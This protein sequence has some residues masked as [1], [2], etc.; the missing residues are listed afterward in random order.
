MVNAI[1]IEKMKHI[2]QRIAQLFLIAVFIIGPVSC[3]K[4]SNTLIPWV[5]VSIQISLANHIDLNAPGGYIY[6]PDQG[7]AGIIVYCVD[8]VSQ[9]Y[10]AFDAACTHDVS[11]NCS[12][13][14]KGAIEGNIATCPCCG[15]KYILFGG[16]YV[17]NGPAKDP[18][19]QYNVQILNGGNNLRIYN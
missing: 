18:L 16:G 1:K 19:K 9:Q 7:Y 17:L 4:D 3:N 13:L 8:N 5:P 11:K 12:L 2:I 14:T 10:Y 15:S 6:F